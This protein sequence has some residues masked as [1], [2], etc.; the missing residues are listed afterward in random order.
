MEIQN[1]AKLIAALELMA[2][3]AD[4]KA[5][6]HKKHPLV[7]KGFKGNAD[8]LRQAAKRISSFT[9]KLCQCE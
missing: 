3:F 2:T 8:T 6:E 5:E 7:E 1:D 4:K 9:G